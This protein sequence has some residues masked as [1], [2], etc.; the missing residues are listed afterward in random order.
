MKTLSVRQPCL[1]GFRKLMRTVL[2]FSAA[3]GLL[4]IN[5][6]NA[7]DEDS[8]PL[9]SCQ[10]ANG[11]K[12][13]ELCSSSPL[14]ADGFL[15]YRFGTLDSN[16][17]EKKVELVYP[18]GRTGSLKQFFGATYTQKG[19]YT[20]SVRF[21]SGQYSYTVYTHAKGARDGDAGVAVRNLSTGKSLEVSCSERP[22]FY[23]YELEG[24]IECDAETPVGKACI[25]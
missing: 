24:L 3:I 8:A 25:K 1:M 20:Q 14:S 12:F 21:S 16:G 11:R 10:A 4:C 5:S 2:F 23:I 19:I 6:A 13:I 18:I 17:S 7:C 9:F 15:Q 22:R